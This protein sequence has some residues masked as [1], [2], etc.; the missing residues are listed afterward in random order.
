M[1]YEERK[2]KCPKCGKNI[3]MKMIKELNVDNL[4]AT[5]SRD[6]FKFRCVYCKNEIIVDYATIFTGSNYEICYKTS[7]KHSNK[8]YSRICDDF[9]DFKEKLLIFSDGLNDIVIEFVK[10]YLRTL[11]NEKNIDIR[12][13]SKNNENLVF[14]IM[15]KNRYIGFDINQYQKLLSHSKIKKIKKFKDINHTNYLKYIKVSI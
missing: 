2:I 14:Y 12:F 6:I 3:K 15:E 1:L 7:K 5:I 9:D 11:I 13:D 4:D 10:D 8:E